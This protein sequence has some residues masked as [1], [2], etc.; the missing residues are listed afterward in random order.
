MRSVAVTEEGSHVFSWLSEH[1]RRVYERRLSAI[2]YLGLI[3]ELIYSFNAAF[4]KV[5][6][7]RDQTVHFWGETG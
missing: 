3:Q 6:H 5:E 1:N 4:W 2:W 7:A